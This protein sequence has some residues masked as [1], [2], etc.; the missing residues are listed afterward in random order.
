MNWP[1]IMKIKILQLI[2]VLIAFGRR[3]KS[4]VAASRMLVERAKF[5]QRVMLS[6]RVS[7]GEGGGC[8]SLKKGQRH[9]PTTAKG[10]GRLS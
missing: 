1:P 5:A 7:F 9:T 10:G 3:D 6:A 8:T 4:T 2:H